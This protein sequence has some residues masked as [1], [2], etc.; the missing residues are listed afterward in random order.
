MSVKYWDGGFK[1]PVKGLFFGALNVSRTVPDH[2]EARAQLMQILTSRKDLQ[3]NTPLQWH[4][5]DCIVLDVPIQDRCEGDALVTDKGNLPI[6]VVT[7]DCAPVLF[8]GV[9]A[10]GS[11]VIGAAHAGARGAA[12]GIV[13]STIAAMRKLGAVEIRAAIGPCIHAQ[14]YE[15]GTDFQD[16]IIAEDHLSYRFFTAKGGDKFAFDLTAYVKDLL[17]RE[18]ISYSFID[19]DTYT[20]PDCFSYRRATHKGEP[21]YGRQLSAIMIAAD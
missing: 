8:H 17:E 11:P 7:A 5:K 18:E 12:R 13:A 3:I 2:P 9:K 10:D 20:D 19:V 6:G 1:A 14:S 4:S 15:V 21:D 16:E